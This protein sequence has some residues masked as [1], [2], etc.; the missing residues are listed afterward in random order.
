MANAIVSSGPLELETEVGTRPKTPGLLLHMVDILLD[1]ITGL[2]VSG[3]GLRVTGL[4]VS[5]F[6]L[7]VGVWGKP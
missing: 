3:F 2:G 5:G 1:E 7:R 6:G 4:G